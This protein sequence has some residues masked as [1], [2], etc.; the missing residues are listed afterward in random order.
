VIFLKITLG[1]ASVPLLRT[2]GTLAAAPL[3]FLCGILLSVS[4][5]PGLIL[6]MTA[7]LLYLSFLFYYVP[8]LYRYSLVRLESGFL[9]WRSGVL[10]RFTTVLRPEHILTVSVSQTPL[11]RMFGLCTLTVQPVGSP[12]RIRQ[13]SCRDALLLKERIAEARHG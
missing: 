10:F 4:P 5:L 8:R 2:D 9:F 11:Q 6:S 3:F 7:A 13:L 1:K 12:V